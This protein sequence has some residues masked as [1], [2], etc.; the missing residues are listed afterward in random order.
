MK[1]SSNKLSLEQESVSEDCDVWSWL[2]LFDPLVS[3]KTLPEGEKSFFL[4]WKWLSRAGGRGH[5][6]QNIKQKRREGKRNRHTSMILSFQGLVCCLQ[7]CYKC[8]EPQLWDGKL[9]AVSSALIV[10]NVSVDPVWLTSLLWTTWTRK[11]YTHGWNT[12]QYS[13]KWYYQFA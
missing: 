11:Q 7:V 4:C 13:H 3:L 8:P 5:Q 9:K 10:H 12:H 2:H 1:Q 6:G